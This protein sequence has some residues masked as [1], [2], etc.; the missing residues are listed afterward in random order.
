MDPL[1]IRQSLESIH[2]SCFGWALHCCGGD[3]E[4][5]EEVLQNA[6]VKVLQGGARHAGAASFKTW[7]FGVVRLTAREEA[8]RSM[9]RRLLL[10]RAAA[11]RE[12]EVAPAR[13]D[14]QSEV[15]E[16]DEAIRG[17]LDQLSQ[18]QRDVLHLVFYQGLTLDD[19]ASVLGVSPGSART[20]YE[21]GKAR[22]R[23]LIETTE[24]ADGRRYQSPA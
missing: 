17:L 1:T 19:A 22:M 21:R 18:R 3:S 11:G 7:F 8:R 13:P 2:Q 5:A 14:H 24:I 10:K 12:P 23:I 20:H 4:M 15:S 6:F 9:A 16:Q